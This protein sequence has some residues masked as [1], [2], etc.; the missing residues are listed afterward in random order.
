M[1]STTAGAVW[2]TPARSP[3]Q[4]PQADSDN[5][6]TPI[7]NL[8]VLEDEL[9]TIRR[10]IQ[11]EVDVEDDDSSLEASFLRGG[12][13]VSSFREKYVRHRARGR[14]LDEPESEPPPLGSQGSHTVEVS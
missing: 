10:H 9:G 4:L 5:V 7:D 1:G 14:L 2:Y 11:F 6:R 3:S 8:L 13:S 12:I